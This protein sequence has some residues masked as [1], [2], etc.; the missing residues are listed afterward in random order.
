M[1]SR[2]ASVSAVA[3]FAL[4][5]FATDLAAQ[6]GSNAAPAPSTDTTVTIT[7]GY[8]VHRDRLRYEFANPSTITTTFL[9]PHRFAQTYA[10]DNQWFVG[11]ARY[12]LWGGTMES[13]FGITPNRATNAS[14]LDTFFNPDDTIVA[15]TDGAVSTHA[16]RAAQ[17]SDGRV[18]GVG[19]R[20]GYVY[21]RDAT[22]FHS[23][24]RIET[25]TN[26]PSETRT[27]IQTHENTTSQAHEIAIGLRHDAPVSA[28]WRLRTAVDVSP[29]I[30]ARLTTILP[31]KYPGQHIVFQ[32]K[33]AGA[34][35]RA[36]LA[37][38]R[39]PL[40]LLFTA[41]LGRTWSYRDDS[42]FVRRSLEVGVRVGIRR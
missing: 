38:I 31:E 23:T 2:V 5:F 33:S 17:W 7:A 28:R 18:W 21:R 13:E 34:I 10:A 4:T 29:V 36:E 24:E 37:W 11:S 1:R 25:H 32:A 16:L 27:P 30:V 9:V 22:I 26:P 14:D 20:L 41:A 39:D 15:G 3:A 12:P 40:P 6:S 42:Q 8:E 35:A 19:L